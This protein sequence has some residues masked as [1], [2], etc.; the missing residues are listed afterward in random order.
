M[1]KKI[2]YKLVRAQ[3][4]AT[5][6]VINMNVMNGKNGIKIDVNVCVDRDSVMN[7]ISN[8]IIINATVNAEM[9]VQKDYN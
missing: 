9:I 2:A 5:A 7:L 3:N 4:N 1:G 6:N 8:G